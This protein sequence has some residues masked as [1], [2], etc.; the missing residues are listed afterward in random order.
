MNDRITAGAAALTAALAVGTGLVRWA[1]VPPRTPGRHRG[2]PQIVPL[3]D[4]LGPP[5]DYTSYRTLTDV[6]A[7]GPI[8]PGFGECEPC[9]TVTAG[10]HNRDG[11][12]CGVCLTPAGAA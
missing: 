7:S 9:G 6:P 1:V 5:S 3:D 11:F 10:S 12:L 2:G 8:T 4:L